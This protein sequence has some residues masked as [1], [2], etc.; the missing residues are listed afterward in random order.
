[1]R[2]YQLL[3][4][5]NKQEFKKLE[6]VL[7]GRDEKGR[8]VSINKNW[9]EMDK[10]IPILMGVSNS[11][12]ENVIF[13]H[14][15]ES[16]WPFSDQANLKKI[17]DE[18]FETTKYTKA[19][20]EM[21]EI[22]K[23]YNKFAK[24][25][26][27]EM[28]VLNKDF[29][30]YK[31]LK[32]KLV[33]LEKEEENFTEG[34]KVKLAMLKEIVKDLADAEKL[35]SKLNDREKLAMMD[36]LALKTKLNDYNDIWKTL[37]VED[38]DDPSLNNTDETQKKQNEIISKKE[39]EKKDSLQ[40]LV[41]LK[42]NLN[43]IRI[44]IGNMQGNMKS[45]EDRFKYTNN[46]LIQ[47]VNKIFEAIG[48]EIEDSYNLMNQIKS[49]NGSAA[50]SLIE[51]AV[52]AFKIKRNKI[53]EEYNEIWKLFNEDLG[54]KEKELNILKT[55]FEMQNQNLKGYEHRLEMMKNEEIS[56][57]SS[58]KELEQIEENLES[59]YNELSNLGVNTK[60]DE[61]SDSTYATPKK[62]RSATDELQQLSSKK[63]TVRQNIEDIEDDIKSKQSILKILEKIEEYNN[64]KD[65]VTKNINGAK[66]KIQSTI[67]KLTKSKSKKNN[68]D[69]SKRVDD[70][71]N[72]TNKNIDK[73][74][75]EKEMLNKK[76]LNSEATL[77]RM[78]YNLKELINKRE[79]LLNNVKQLANNHI[80]LE[81]ESNHDLWNQI[82]TNFINDKFDEF[83]NE[84]TWLKSSN[85]DFNS[86]FDTI[87]KSWW[88]SKACFI[89]KKKLKKSD[90]DSI[91]SQLDEFAKSYNEF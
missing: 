19:L 37:E 22:K 15:E 29:E 34:N 80:D 32:E 58:K 17:F 56:W 54:N 57:K 26:K 4:R 6:Q 64:R 68:I 77:E 69:L 30:H 5:K 71:I 72:S 28:E 13:C 23:R 60:S 51:N 88:D 50:F 2:V 10:Q 65:E 16:L 7:K 47:N 38:I 24:E 73:L 9:A 44:E 59:I 85:K 55:Q 18:I 70:L 82:T 83:C 74:W 43:K 75:T 89:C 8:E 3:N 14:Q 46:E 67:E 25:Y 66:T 78:N 53:S 49:K 40:K 33:K 79:Q 12:L 81:A 87:Y 35:E 21:R 52:E 90:F 27:H 61:D 39:E 48:D 41:N 45:K 62:I 76:M 86:C 36:Q 20:V 11:I 42:E 31:K 91:K 1:M 84:R 63:I